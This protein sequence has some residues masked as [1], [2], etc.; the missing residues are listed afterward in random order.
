[1]GRRR[2]ISLSP[3]EESI[4]LWQDAAVPWNT[5]VA[6]SA[7]RIDT[8]RV[9]AAF[10]AAMARHPLATCAVERDERACLH[11]VHD[12][13]ADIGTIE[14]IDC[15]DEASLQQVRVE[16]LDRA[17]PMDVAPLMRAV[18][19]RGPSEDILIV[20]VSH[21]MSDGLGLVRL[22]RSVARA[23]RNEP[24]PSP[25]V[26]IATA[27]RAL[28]PEPPTSWS[29]LTDRWTQR[30]R[31]ASVQVKRRSRLADSGGSAQGG[32]GLITRSIDAADITAARRR[33][34]VA[35]DEYAM[36]ALHVT[37]A[38]WNRDHGAA[39]DVVGVTQGVN[40]RA[41]EWWN[42]VVVNLAAFASVMTDAA[43]RTDIAAALTRVRP[44]LDP[45]L[46]VTHAREVASA[47]RAMRVLPADVRVKA[48][49]TLPADQFDTCTISNVGP[50]AD[51]PRL[52]DGEHSMRWIATPAMPVAGVTIATAM[53]DEQLQLDVCFRKERLDDDGAGR[54][55]DAFIATLAAG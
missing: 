26:D 16:Q 23:Y 15:P 30:L 54:F 21:V 32:F 27:H 46:R 1:V 38:R 18:I 13:A 40:L 34:G 49:A 3:I 36:A 24:D 7:P 12:D 39:C 25:A 4:L 22:M 9:R 55:V 33:F 8:D 41:D 35:F 29:A 28:A 52:A 51:P 45:S 44:Q 17:L 10:G 48:L 42:D 14:V 37:I 20:C 5:Q 53:V 47:A 31:V 19:A 50:L 43:D 2:L 6:L 11:W